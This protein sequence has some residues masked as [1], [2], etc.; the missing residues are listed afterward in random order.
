MKKKFLL[1]RSAK[2]QSLVEMAISLVIILWLLAG[3]AEFAVIL[4][5]YI[6]L[7]DAAQEGA[8]YGSINPPKDAADTAK[9]TAIENR[10]KGAASTP[11]DLMNDPNVTVEV[12]VTDGRYCEGGSLKVTVKYPHKVFMPFM[13]QILGA[14][15]ELEADVTDTILT[16]PPK[17]ATS[18]Y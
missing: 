14:T 11:I 9:F 2:G 8:L 6:E 3:A 10:A 15:R 7:R 18:C 1:P 12:V 13:S 16:P 4:F 17:S 5:Q